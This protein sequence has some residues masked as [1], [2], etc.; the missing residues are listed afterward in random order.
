MKINASSTGLEID[1]D[2]GSGDVYLEVKFSIFNNYHTETDFITILL[3]FRGC[4]DIL[5][6]E[7]YDVS[8][9]A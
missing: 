6:E 7:V 2:L 4:D 1:T 8:I 9:A 3:A 5:Y